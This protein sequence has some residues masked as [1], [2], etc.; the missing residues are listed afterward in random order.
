MHKTEH[1]VKNC[2]NKDQQENLKKEG[3]LK[4]ISLRLIND[5]SK[6]NVSI[7]V[8]EVKS[9]KNPEE[10]WVNTSATRHVCADKKMFSTYKEVDGEHL[11]MKNSLIS[12][13]LGIGKIILKMTYKK[14]H[15]LNNI[16]HVTDIRKDLVSVFLLGKNNF[17]MIVKINKFVLLKNGM[18]F[19]K[20]AYLCDD[21][22][23][24]NSITIIK[25]DEMNNNNNHYLHV[26]YNSTQSLI[27][28]EYL[29]SIVFEKNH[30]C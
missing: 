6:L 9:I 4:L 5:V 7:V 2:I 24:I 21:L 15:T 30:K 1:Q 10:L 27:N 19:E 23:K 17:K 13:V 14:L 26:N 12:K 20:D 18:F 11:Y 3:L 25:N 28:I 16:L 8:F 22:F 29:P